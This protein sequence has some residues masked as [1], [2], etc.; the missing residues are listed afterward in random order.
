M[1]IKIFI[2]SLVTSALLFQSCKGTDTPKDDFDYAGQALIDD[3]KI[4]EFLETH[5]Y[6]PPTG[7]ENF[8]VIDTILNGETPIKNIAE[9]KEVK[10]NKVD[11]KLYFVKALPEGSGESPSIL[12]KVFVKYQGI[13]LDAE[14]KVFDEVAV[15]YTWLSLTGVI[16]GWTYGFPNFRAGST[17]ISGEDQ[18]IEFDQPGRGVLFIPSGLGYSNLG[19]GSIP[20]NTPLIFHIKL[21]F[22]ERGDQDLDGIYSIFEDL[23]G[24]NDFVNDDTDGDKRPNYADDDDD[25]DGLKTKYETADPNEDHNPNDALDTDNDGV[26]NFLDNDDDGDGII[27]AL[28]EADPN[29]DGNPEDAVDSDGDQIPDYL[30]PT[31]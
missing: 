13:T 23:N 6:T 15:N 21:G 27:T 28:E 5:F 26:P 7:N 11:Y 8:G 12:D 25:N 1:K 24:D 18:P 14:K 2:L 4:N 10:Y 9:V 16:P 3:D 22:I 31:N 20:P 29:H 19:S 17:I 30:D